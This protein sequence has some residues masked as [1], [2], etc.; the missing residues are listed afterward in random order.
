MTEDSHYSKCRGDESITS[1][2]PSESTEYQPSSASLA[3]QYQERLRERSQ[4]ARRSAQFI[5]KS[6]CAAR[7]PRNRVERHS[8]AQSASSRRSRGT[9]SDRYAHVIEK[10]SHAVTR[11]PIE[12]NQRRTNPIRRSPRRLIVCA[13]DEPVQSAF[14]LWKRLATVGPHPLPFSV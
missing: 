12:R 5:S 10:P 7:Q 2:L 13:L 4:R 14:D 6:S 8:E 9:R 3:F 1:A 11:Y